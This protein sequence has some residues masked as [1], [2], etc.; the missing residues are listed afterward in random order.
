[1]AEEVLLLK[2]KMKKLIGM[3]LMLLIS[4]TIRAAPPVDTQ[5]SLAHVIGAGNFSCGKFMQYKAENDANQMNIIQ[6]WVWGFMV[7]YDMR[8]NFRHKFT[9]TIE[10]NL[11]T[12]PDGPTVFLFL[13]T[14]CQQHPL[15]TVLDGTIALIKQ[16]GGQVDWKVY[17]K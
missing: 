12:M 5:P 16:M 9:R 15:D 1:V 10:G 14:H 8:S 2:I 17:S 4:T 6:Q 7:A 13:A 11:S 3:S